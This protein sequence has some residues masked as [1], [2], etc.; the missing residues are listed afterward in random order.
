MRWWIVSIVIH[1]GFSSASGCSR[2]L[3][4]FQEVREYAARLEMLIERDRWKGLPKYESKAFDSAL[5]F[6]RGHAELHE[7][8][9]W[10]R[11]SEFHLVKI[12]PNFRK[13]M[14]ND[15][16]GCEGVKAMHGKRVVFPYLVC[17]G[18]RPCEWVVV[19]GVVRYGKIVDSD[20]PV[21]WFNPKLTVV[22][23]DPTTATT[24]DTLRATQ[25][26]H[27]FDFAIS[28][29]PFLWTSL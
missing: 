21:P 24:I 27:Q 13:E 10:R 5:E 2:E 8:D 19:A 4:Q 29:I 6:A 3:I 25:N 9:P 1:W 22:P 15:Y 23:F 7:Y 14:E 28:S 18:E 12:S 16:W 20:M 26:H 11:G 17:Y